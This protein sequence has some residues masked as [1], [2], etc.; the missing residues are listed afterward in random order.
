[1]K[2]E[3][4]TVKGRKLLRKRTTDA[5][6]IEALDALDRKNAQIAGAKTLI[7]TLAEK[8]E[9][10]CHS[11]DIL[12]YHDLLPGLRIWWPERFGTDEEEDP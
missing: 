12:R 7:Q 10:V 3:I 1:M 4:D 2:T 8:L 9:G 6:L 5:A 11:P